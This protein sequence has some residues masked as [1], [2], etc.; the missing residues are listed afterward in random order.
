MYMFFEVP[1]EL[2][3]FL[4]VMPTCYD[5]STSAIR[6]DFRLNVFLRHYARLLRQVHFSN[7]SG[8]QTELTSFLVIKPACYNRSTSAVPSGCQARLS[9]LIMMPA[10][11]SRLTSA[12]THSHAM[13]IV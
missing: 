1:S 5:M 6:L 9:F 4:V 8:F 11:Y 7:S 13:Q 2:T 3:S 10:C 12:V